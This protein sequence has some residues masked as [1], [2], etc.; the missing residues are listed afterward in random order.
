MGEIKSFFE[1]GDFHLLEVGLFRSCC[2]SPCCLG[3]ASYRSEAL[4]IS[5]HQIAHCVK[6][7]IL[8]S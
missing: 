1:A 8:D 5:Q 7:C 6:E 2:V 3:R 4:S